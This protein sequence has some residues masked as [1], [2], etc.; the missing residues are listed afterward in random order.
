MTP[1]NKPYM[2][3]IPAL[4]EAWRSQTNPECRFRGRWMGVWVRDQALKVIAKPGNSLPGYSKQAGGK[5]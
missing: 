5:E 3:L 1:L 4:H 2:N